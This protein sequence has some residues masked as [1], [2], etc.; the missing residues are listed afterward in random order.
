MRGDALRAY[1]YRLSARVNGH[2]RAL[3]LATP[4]VGDM[5]IVELP[6]ADGV[7]LADV[8]RTLWRQGIYVTLAAYPLVPRDQVGFRVQ[9]TALHTDED[10]ERLAGVLT[11]L[12]AEGALRR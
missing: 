12:T 9:L 11:R 5:P 7:D 8:A 1:L 3:G 6:L 4:A 2:V 10:V